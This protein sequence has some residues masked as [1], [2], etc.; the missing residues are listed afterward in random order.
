MAKKAVKQA[1]LTDSPL[2][3]SASN[4][5]SASEP[6]YTPEE[7]GYRSLLLKKLEAARTLRES[8]HDKFNGVGY[9]KWYED[10]DK[11]ANS[12]TPPRKNAD[13]VN[14]VTGT[15]REKVLAIVSNVI[16][17][18]FR[19][20]FKAFD[21]DDNEEVELGEAMSD[22]VERSTQ[23]ELWEEKKIFP[24]YEMAA[25]GDVF[26]ED[27]EVDEVKVDK[28]K[29]KLSSVKEGFDFENFQPEKSMK[30][31]FSGCRRNVLIGT[32][33]YLGNIYETEINRQPYIFTREILPYETAKVIYGHLPRWKYVPKSLTPA[34]AEGEA[35]HWGLNWRLEDVPDGMVE[36]IK[37]TDDPNDEYQ[38]VLNS[39]FQLPVGFP[40][41]WEF[42]GYNIVQGGLEPMGLFAYHKSIPCK[43]KV[44]QEVIDEMLKLSVLKGQKSYMPPI[45]N[46]SG[47]LLT[48]S[49][50]NA[51]KVT[52][53]LQKGDIEVLGGN[54]AMYQMN[55]SEFQL[56]EMLKKFIDD[57]SVNPFMQGQSPTRETTATEVSTVMAQAKRNLGIMIFGFMSFH[58]KLDILRLNNLLDGYTKPTGDILDKVKNTLVKKYRTVSLEKEIGNKGMGTKK[59][60]FTTDFKSPMALYDEENGISRGEDGITTAVNPPSKPVKITQVNP[61]TLRSV[62]YRWYGEVEIKEK[63]TSM[64]E[65]IMFTDQLAT[66]MKL[67]GV[68]AVNQD[69]AR[70]QWAQKNKVNAKLFFNN[71]VM[72]PGAGSMMQEQ[73]DKVEESPMT[74]GMRASPSGVPAAVRQ[75]FGGGV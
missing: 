36:V 61:E 3:A 74:K 53:N 27:I 47:Q 65:R 12:H 4:D 21:K 44:D 63:E 9:T 72:L 1:K 37:Y 8:S 6:A 18:I 28:K 25:Q 15:T 43:T 33:V 10:N 51:G 67:F 73:V 41:P 26:V 32:Q 59:V 13:D 5:I 50:F 58:L 40:K 66:A 57:K 31:M 16:N 30:T 14:I 49:M 75:G 29:I 19:T 38:I 64:Q 2:E 7:Q 23:V 35:A 54:P 56:I 22:C 52:N 62:K 34:S 60:D 70:A 45:A 48:R 46:Y 11:A 69:Y 17:L 68:E 20:N 24:Y 39:V 71:G 55:T 42:D